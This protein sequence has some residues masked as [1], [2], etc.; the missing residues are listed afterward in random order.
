MREHSVGTFG[1]ELLKAYISDVIIAIFDLHE[2]HHSRPMKR[3]P[4]RLILN[5]LQQI[6]TDRME[7]VHTWK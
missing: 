5:H 6:T 7:V 3:V 2:F 4:I 1:S